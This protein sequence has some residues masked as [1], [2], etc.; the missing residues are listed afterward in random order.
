MTLVTGATGFVGSHLLEKLRSRGEAV[1]C[2]VRPATDARR[3]PAGVETAAADL[4]TGQ[5]ID[6]ALSG[7]DTV[8]HVAG[9]TKALSTVDYV[10]GN[11]RA[12]ETLVRA[13]VSRGIR[14]VYVSSLAA[15]GPS[16]DGRPV[17]EESAPHP[18]STYGKSKLE[19]EKIARALLPDS[20]IVRPPVVYG[21][22]DTG[23]FQI[24]KAV[25]NGLVLEIAGGERWFSAIYVEDLAEGICAA[26][27]ASKAAGRAYFL[28]HREPVSW[29]QLGATA[30]QIMGRRPRTIRVPV[31]VAKSVAFFAEMW[32]RISRN[33][34]IISRE[35]VA[36]A[37]YGFWTC[38][39]ARATADF[40]FEAPTPLAAG[41]AKTLGWYKEA[42]WLK[43]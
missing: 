32:S 8:I 26:A 4:V 1:R 3:L 2:L 6:H 9:V 29:R 24:L 36:E 33:P 22:R 19:G 21:P 15:I 23:V 42:G 43:Y 12:T 34:A 31:T 30:A 17:N 14:L 11:A 7:V 25:A 20:V 28:A 18:V 5:G 13:L 38:E 39:P 35:K 16:L 41:L 10:T 37:C 27:R 40:G